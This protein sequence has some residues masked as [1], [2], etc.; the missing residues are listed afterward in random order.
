MPSTPSYL[1]TYAALEVLLGFSS[2]GFLFTCGLLIH[3]IILENSHRIDVWSVNITFFCVWMSLFDW[4]NLYGVLV[5][6]TCVTCRKPTSFRR[7]L[8]R[9]SGPPFD[10]IKSDN[11]ITSVICMINSQQLAARLRPPLMLR[12]KPLFVGQP[13]DADLV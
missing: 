10:V 12:A 7:M 13:I 11:L 6:S 9:K 1:D 8:K 4:W 3:Y 2:M 5:T